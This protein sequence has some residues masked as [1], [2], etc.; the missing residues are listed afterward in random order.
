MTDCLGLTTP[1]A[2]ILFLHA[3]TI[4]PSTNDDRQ[5]MYSVVQWTSLLGWHNKFQSA[6]KSGREIYNQEYYPSHHWITYNI[7]AVYIVLWLVCRGC[8]ITCLIL[9]SSFVIA[10]FY[11]I[12]KLNFLTSLMICFKSR[13]STAAYLFSSELN[14]RHHA[15]FALAQWL[16][17][18][19]CDCTILCR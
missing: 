4:Q 12:L 3:A 16:E 11:N 9:C 14:R 19:N 10:V 2:T 5:G 1:V 6:L 8:F 17:H 18:L 7:Y 13:S 15:L